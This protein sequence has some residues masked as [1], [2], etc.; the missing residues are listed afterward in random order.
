MGQDDL[1]TF[2][3]GR[4]ADFVILEADPLAYIRHTRRISR[5]VK[6]GR[7]LDPES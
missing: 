3:P 5:V 7:M 1:G 4:L 6:G 2:E